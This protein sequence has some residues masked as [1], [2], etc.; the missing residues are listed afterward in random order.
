MFLT[1]FKSSFALRKEATINVTVS[2]VDLTGSRR[3]TF[4]VKE[5]G[6][7]SKAYIHGD[8]VKKGDTYWLTLRESSH[9]NY[10]AQCCFIRTVIDQ[11]LINQLTT[12]Q[13]FDLTASKIAIR[14]EG[15][16]FHGQ[17]LQTIGIGPETSD[18]NIYYYLVMRTVERIIRERQSLLT[19]QGRHTELNYLMARL[20]SNPVFQP[21]LLFSILT[22]LNHRPPP[23]T[24][25]RTIEAETRAMTWGG[26]DIRT[27]L[28]EQF[29]GKYCQIVKQE[30]LELLAL[31]RKEID[32]RERGTNK[33][34]QIYALE[35]AIRTKTFPETD[36]G[37]TRLAAYTTLAERLVRHKRG[38]MASKAHAL[39]KPGFTHLRIM[40]KEGFP[41]AKQHRELHYPHKS[42][43]SYF[44]D[45]KPI[46]FAL[47]QRSSHAIYAALDA[48]TH[49]F[50]GNLSGIDWGARDVPATTYG[51]IS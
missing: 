43:C 32:T 45:S 44:G 8:L 49:P 9:F 20:T 6:S 48:I 14:H 12:S 37:A 47:H 10:P 23:E 11:C 25:T 3:F 17:A 4:Y 46:T 50:D 29:E 42:C 41:S 13:A 51:A 24:L 5:P 30:L 22:I 2:P 21:S 27:R 28:K 16:H 36:G 39:H 19:S 34:V 38:C 35:E 15:G 18:I 1:I 33:T 7:K 40:M 26:K 31:C